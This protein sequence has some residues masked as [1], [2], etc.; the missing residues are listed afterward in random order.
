MALT[1]E[2]H[3]LSTRALV[4][5]ASP[6]IIIRPALTIEPLVTHYRRR[7]AAYRFVRDVL[8]AAFGDHLGG[9]NRLTPRGPVEAGL[10]VELDGMIELFDGAADHA[11][12][13]I[14]LAAAT[15]APL[16]ARAFDWRPRADPDLGED[17]RAMVPL[18]RDPARGLTRVWAVLGWSERELVVRFARKP[19]ITLPQGMRT[20]PRFEPLTVA[21]LTPAVAELDVARVLD[22]DEF[23][24]L[25]DRHAT[26]PAILAAL[27]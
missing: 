12:E 15:G 23:R 7:A 16:S 19:R 25:C 1:A 4:L 18:F 21:V 14:G 10:D 27:A 11:A 17:I 3:T 13:E 26:R 9:L 22:R 8:A 5:G 2:S 6:R 24:R 20:R